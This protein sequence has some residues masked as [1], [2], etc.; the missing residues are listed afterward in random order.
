MTSWPVSRRNSALARSAP[1]AVRAE[2]ICGSSNSSVI[3]LPSAM[4][5]GQK[6]TSMSMPSAATVFST[7]AVT[8]G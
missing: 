5:S 1:R 7:S 8:P 6:A 2:T 3:A 4:R